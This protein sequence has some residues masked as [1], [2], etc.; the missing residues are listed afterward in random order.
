MII[1]I[2]PKSN[3]YILK[4]LSNNIKVILIS[5]STIKDPSL[6]PDTQYC[7]LVHLS[8]SHTLIA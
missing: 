2:M 6:P 3:D 1:I 5:Y 7:R 4:I 8:L